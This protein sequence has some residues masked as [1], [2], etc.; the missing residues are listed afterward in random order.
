MS[1]PLAPRRFASRGRDAPRNLRSRSPGAGLAGRRWPQKRRSLRECG[2]LAGTGMRTSPTAPQKT[3]L[4]KKWGGR[5]FLI[6]PTNPWGRH[7][8]LP[9]PRPDRCHRAARHPWGRG[10]PRPPPSARPPPPSP[11]FPSAAEFRPRLRAKKS[12]AGSLPPGRRLLQGRL[13]AGPLVATAAARA[14]GF[15]PEAR[16]GA[17]RGRRRHARAADTP[18]RRRCL[19]LRPPAAAGPASRAAP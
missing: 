3:P 18:A 6:P 7:S 11:R 8:C 16:A 2:P 17:D 9:A 14:R 4:R 19:P 1:A 10:R 13:A 15:P 5:A 12:R